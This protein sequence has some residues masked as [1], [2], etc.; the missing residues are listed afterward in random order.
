MCS[1]VIQDAS[2]DLIQIIEIQNR[3]TDNLQLAINV[4]IDI[5]WC[6]GVHKEVAQK[7][8]IGFWLWLVDYQTSR[9]NK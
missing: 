7:T 4:R 9:A 3:Y 6:D 1:T 2:G 8:P 5:Q